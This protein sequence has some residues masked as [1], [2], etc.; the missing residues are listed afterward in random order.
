MKRLWCWSLVGLVSLVGHAHAQA[1]VFKKDSTFM[2]WQEGPTN[3]TLRNNQLYWTNQGLIA[4]RFRDGSLVTVPL[5]GK[6]VQV[7]ADKLNFPGPFVFDA[8]H[9]YWTNMG[10]KSDASIWRLPITGGKSQ[11]IVRG[12]PDVEYL[13]VGPRHVYFARKV[14]H[15]G[16]TAIARV[17]K[18]GGASK[19]VGTVNKLIGAMVLHRG[20]LY[21]V[22]Y[23]GKASA[24]I[25][26]DPPSGKTAVLARGVNWRQ[27]AADDTGLYFVQGKNLMRIA[28]G[29]QQPKRFVRNRRFRAGFSLKLS[30][31]AIYWISAS[32]T[33]RIDRKKRRQRWIYRG[34]CVDAV[35]TPT[36]LYCARTYKEMIQ[37]VK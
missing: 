36:A 25:R 27:L 35:A 4:N 26:V 6:K 2:A 16:F 32:G 12:L 30:T 7:L 18:T 28:P 19:F 5:T 22:G 15:K 23:W 21:V 8:T 13:A 20:A 17:A 3:I 31:D 37:V 33:I 10:Y 24:L 1:Q 34:R 29:K 11:L 14:R 9:I